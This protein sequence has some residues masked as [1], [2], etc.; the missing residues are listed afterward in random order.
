MGERDGDGDEEMGW[1]RTCAVTGSRRGAG[2][3]PACAPGPGR[4]PRSCCWADACAAR[5]S[6]SVPHSRRGMCI[7]RSAACWVRE[8][9]PADAVHTVVL[10]TY[11][12]FVTYLL[13]YLLT[14]L[15]VTLLTY[16]L[17]YFILRI[18]SQFILAPCCCH[19]RCK[20]LATEVLPGERAWTWAGR[21][22]LS[23][24]RVQVVRRRATRSFRR[25]A[26]RLT[27]D[28][29]CPSRTATPRLAEKGIADVQRG[30]R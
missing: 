11:L 2:G 8:G 19:V 30:S 23:E 12:S 24:P 4:T 25:H 14:Y 9:T 27:R 21:T 7:V 18:P 3:M 5:S 16:L 13:T 6:K 15:V 10:L 26:A 29:L 22:P 28:W 1:R 20:R 17:T